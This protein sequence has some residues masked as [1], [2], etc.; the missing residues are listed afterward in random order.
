LTLDQI[1]LY[2][3]E[4]SKEN[5][6]SDMIDGDEMSQGEIEMFNISMGIDTKIIPKK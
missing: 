4:W 6:S 3:K 1:R 5:N 2:F